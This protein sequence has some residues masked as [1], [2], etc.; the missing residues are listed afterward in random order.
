MTRISIGIVSPPGYSRLWPPYSDRLENHNTSVARD[1]NRTLSTGSSTLIV[2]CAPGRRGRAGTL[3]LRDSLVPF[4][5]G[6][7]DSGLEAGT[8]PARS[9]RSVSLKC[10]RVRGIRHAARTRRIPDTGASCGPVAPGKT[11]RP[12]GTRIRAE[13][14]P[15]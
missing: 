9:P 2:G 4:G 15:R 12:E 10:G 5:P 14:P 3:P 6:P 8:G 7:D 11:A 1:A 13:R